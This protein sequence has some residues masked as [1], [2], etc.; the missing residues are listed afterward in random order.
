MKTKLI[1]AM[2][3]M[4]G[5][6]TFTSCSKDDD[7]NND[8]T[9]FNVIETTPLVDQDNYS[10]NTTAAN[11]AVKSFGE[12]AIEGCADVVSQLEAANA[13]IGSAKLSEA[14]ETYLREVLRNLVNNVIV[15]TYTKLADNTEALEKTLHGLTTSTITQAQI[16][17]ACKDFK[18]ARFRC[19]PHH[20]LMAAEPL[21]VAQLL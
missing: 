2:A 3:L 15:P 8:E 19:R 7:K 4:M 1:L 18:A 10:A 5:A 14:Q 20:R 21:A 6:M 11:Y 13:V 17:E 12:T 16:D 9:A